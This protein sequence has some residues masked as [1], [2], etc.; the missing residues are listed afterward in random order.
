MLKDCYFYS[1]G[2]V[3]VK[4]KKKIVHSPAGT[5]CTLCFHM[6]PVGNWLPIY[7]MSKLTHFS[8]KIQKLLLAYSLINNAI[9]KITYM[10][11]YLFILRL[12]NFFHSHVLITI[13]V[14]IFFTSRKYMYITCMTPF[15]SG[16][17]GKIWPIP[18][19]KPG[20]KW[21]HLFKNGCA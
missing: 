1:A 11:M 13:F 12:N 20:L 17:K 6:G 8:I 18:R 5:Q 15:S 16:V 3:F 21:R 9:Q 10:Y 7:W 19:E 4:I 2:H 14:V